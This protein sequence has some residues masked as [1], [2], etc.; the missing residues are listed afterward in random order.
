MNTYDNTVPETQN[1][2]KGLNA[3][4][5]STPCD[6]CSDRSIYKYSD[7]IITN[8]ARAVGL[9][10]TD[11]SYVT[12]NCSGTLINNYQEK[13]Y[14]LSAAH[15]I[16]DIFEDI[17]SPQDLQKFNNDQLTDTELNSAIN[18][19][20]SNISDWVFRL[21]YECSSSS[22]IEN[23][24][25]VSGVK[26]RSINNVTD[27]ALF[28]LTGNI[29]ST[30]KSKIRLAGW[31]NAQSTSS[32]IGIHH[33]DYK[34][35]KVAL[36]TSFKIFDNSDYM[37][38]WSTNKPRNLY[39]YVVFYE[40]GVEHGSS[41]SSL[42]NSDGQVVGFLTGGEEDNLIDCENDE[43]VYGSL[44]GAWTYSNYKSLPSR[45]L[46]TWL[47]NTNQTSMPSRSFSA[48]IIVSPATN[49]NIFNDGAPCNYNEIS[50]GKPNLTWNPG[51]N[52]Y[53]KIYRGG[54]L[55]ATITNSATSSFFDEEVRSWA[56]N[57]TFKS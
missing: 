7:P 47:T 24:F 3:R 50:C 49:L 10:Y 35:K 36:A 16:Y 21:Q 57:G 28:E 32:A 34:P 43:V 29:S 13:L 6:Y 8:H 1:E 11:N 2:L 26:L 23:G 41:G 31:S 20:N 18:V 9:F 42:I 22:Q 15:C 51:E 30:N 25:Y 46:K 40:G 48:P 45:T 19:V 39:W 54:T 53:Y 12:R 44:F 27:M 38:T 17:L 56:T 52:V 33:P 14:V 4:R 5:T 37:P 55:I